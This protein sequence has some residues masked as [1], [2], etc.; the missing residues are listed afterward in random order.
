L[1][2][3]TALRQ[4]HEQ[5]RERENYFR[6]LIENSTDIISVLRE[7]GLVTYCSPSSVRQLGYGLEELVGRNLT[8]FLHPDIRAGFLQMIERVIDAPD[9]QGKASLRIRHKDG[10]WRMLETVIQVFSIRAGLPTTVVA[11]SRDI[12]ERLQL[13]NLLRQSQKLDAI[14]QL[15]G[16]IAH[17]FNN[18]LTAVLIHLS[19]LKTDPD[20]NPKLK[21][22]LTDL[23]T[24]AL[25][26]ANLTRQLLLFS[27]PGTAQVKPVDLDHVISNLARMLGRVLGERIELELRDSNGDARISAD[28]GMLEQVVMNLCIN[29]RDAMVRGGRLKVS[30]SLKHIEHLAA[31]ANIKARPG[32]FVCLEVRDTGSGMSPDVLERIFEPFF[33]TKEPGKGTGLGLA[34]VYGIIK[35][36]DGWIDVES[37]LGQ[38]TSFLIYFPRLTA[39]AQIA[40]ESKGP[41]Q[42]PGGKETVL[43][44]EDDTPLRQLVAL[45]LRKMG[46]AVMEATD[47]Q[48]ALKVFRESPSPIDLLLTD[49]VMPGETTGLEL[50]RKLQQEHSG[51]K[52]LVS[53]GYHSEISKWLKTNVD[54]K[55]DYLAKPYDA[56]ALARAVRACLKKPEAR[57]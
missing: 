8:A 50:A 51:L 4:A 14:G 6:S 55:A 7:D 30:T 23:E 41:T 33:T 9:T 49:V 2:D 16:G 39:T 24:E 3:T 37:E 28:E 38:G 11:N 17:D 5:L 27:R 20:L 47:G 48:D 31:A 56:S 32:D 44:V 18:I 57:S 15:V 45:W 53:S 10:S 29:A 13:E 12:T 36:L 46:Y 22:S 52:V 1:I 34:T 43:W 54:L 35:Q 21:D 19:L 42:L 25:R 26:A 40:A